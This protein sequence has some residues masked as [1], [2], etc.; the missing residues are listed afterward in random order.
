MG[1]LPIT[2]SLAVTRAA[3]KLMLGFSDDDE[4]RDGSSEPWVDFSTRL[5]KNTW[6]LHDSVL[7]PI[8]GDGGSAA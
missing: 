5:S 6:D 8:L 3:A 2:T 4:N 7:K 1:L